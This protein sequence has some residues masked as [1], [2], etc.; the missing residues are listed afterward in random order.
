MPR[1]R[2]LVL[3][4]RFPYPP[5]GGDRLRIYHICRYLAK[6]F[7]LSLLSL[8]ETEE[9]MEQE[10]PQDGIFKHLERIPHGLSARLRGIA[11]AI[12]RKAPIQVGYYK[13]K[14]FEKRLMELASNH[15]G[16]VAHLVRTAPYALSLQIPRIV[17]MTDAISMS[18]RR[19]AA[20]SRGLKGL[21]YREEARRLREFEKQV[22]N[23]CM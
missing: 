10:V 4:P 3:T 1:R 13:S 9:E 14:P 2:I 17:E 11:W 8:C 21:M 19:A 12:P 15:D 23:L 5:V 6:E 20:K 7:D 16:V 22:I 18:Y